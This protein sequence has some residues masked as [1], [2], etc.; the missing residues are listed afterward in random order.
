MITYTNKK[1]GNMKSFKV[2][3]IKI[4]DE[5]HNFV[6]SEGQ[7]HTSTA[8]KYPEYAASLDAYRGSEKWNDSK[9]KYYTQVVQVKVDG[10]LVQD[11][12]PWKL[13]D[14]EDVFRVLNHGFYDE[15]A[16]TDF[17]YE[18]HLF[19]YNKKTFVDKEGNTQEYADFHSLSVGDIVEDPNGDFFLV[20]SFG[21]KQILKNREVA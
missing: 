13:E 14:L 18:N 11:G 10:G 17:V 21:F 1:G 2:Y 9:F 4:S 19:D 15:E 7:S 12:K 8:E 6:N 16:G 3:Q 5:I 20:D